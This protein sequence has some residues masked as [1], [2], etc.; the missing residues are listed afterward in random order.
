MGYVSDGSLNPPTRILA[1]VPLA[2][3]RTVEPII[4]EQT[5]G[6]ALSEAMAGKKQ[7]VLL[8]CLLNLL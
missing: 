1:K 2:G 5:A 6:A 7:L 4:F 8:V 3:F